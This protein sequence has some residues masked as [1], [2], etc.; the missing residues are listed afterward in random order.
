MSF[1]ARSHSRYIEKTPDAGLNGQ[2]VT[3]DVDIY[4]RWNLNINWTLIFQVNVFSENDSHLSI[5]F[6]SMLSKSIRSG[7]NLWRMAQ[8]ASPFLQ[9][10]DMSLIFT[11][12]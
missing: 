11:L 1:V 10:E 2:T 9:E 5:W 8:K 12:G 3:N 6:G 7:L 4:K